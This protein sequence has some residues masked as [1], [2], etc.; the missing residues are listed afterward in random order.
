M[1]PRGG[2][3]EV[4]NQGQR[5]LYSLGTE[6]RE[7]GLSSSSFQHLVRMEE[8]YYW[9]NVC[10]ARSSMFQKRGRRRGKKNSLESR[11]TLCAGERRKGERVLSRRKGAGDMQGSPANG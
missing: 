5:L 11:V 3:K 6:E 7:N 2:G 1:R 9:E 4:G 10:S 8:K